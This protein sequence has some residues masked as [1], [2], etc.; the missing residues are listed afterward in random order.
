MRRFLPLLVSCLLF[1]VNATFATPVHLRC[2]YLENP[3]GLDRLAPRLSWQSD[4]TQRDWKQAAYQILVASTAEALK[5]GA[6]VWDS[7]RQD[8]D[9]SVNIAYHGPALESRRRYYWKV[10][11]WDAAGTLSESTQSA[12]WEMGL[13]H[14]DDWKAKWITW[15]NPDSESDLAN[16]RW[17][18]V[19]GQDAMSVPPKTKADFRLTVS[20]QQKPKSAALFVAG[21]GD[22]LAKVN[23]HPVG[24]KNH[25]NT[26]DRFEISDQ[27]VVGENAV[28]L[29][30]TSPD[31]PEFGPDASKPA[32]AALAALVKVV[33]SDGKVQ[34]FATDS[35]WK[36]KLQGN[37]SDWQPASVVAELSDSRLGDPGPLPDPASYL[38]HT[39]Q[40]SKSVR[41]AR[42]YVT[43]LGSYRVSLNGKDVSENVL[44]PEFTDYRKRVLY[45]TYDVTNL[46]ASGSNAIG[47]LLGDGWYGSPL[48][49]YGIHYF[50]LPDR[51]LAQLEIIY[52]DG[53]RDSVL[54][55]GAWK[56][57]PSPIIKSTIYDGE[58]YDARLEQSGWNQS[59]FADT[60]WSSAVVTEAPQIAVSSQIDSPV[61]VV[62]TI[63]PKHITPLS[64]GAYLFDMGQNMVGWATLKVKGS[65]GTKVQLRFAEI[66]NPDGTIYTQNLRNAA[67]TDSYV[68]RGGAEETF[69]PHFTFHGFRY[70]EVSGYPGKPTLGSITGNV[71]SS[72]GGDPVGK[73]QTSS[74]LVNHMWSIGIWGQRGNFVSIPTDCPQR[75]ER[76]GW[77]GDAE[78]F[79][80]TGSYNFDIAA[81][82]QKF[83]QDVIDAQSK[84]GAFSNVSPNVL[85]QEGEFP[86][87]S[88]P[89]IGAPGWGDAGVI[90]PWTAW[91]Q[92]GNTALLEDS[93]TAMD[94]WMELI[95]RHNPDYVRKNAL[96]F[97]FADWLAPDENTDKSLLAT[98]YWAL[99]A[100]MMSQMGHAIGKDADAKRYDELFQHIRGSFQKE[101]V[102]SDGQVGTGTQTSYVVALYTE[103]A[104]VP[105]EREMVD[106][107]VKDI[108]SHNWHLTTGFLG[109][110]FLLFTLSDHGRSDVA[111]RLLLNDTYPS[112]GYMLAKGATTWWERWNGDTGDPAMNSYNH[113]AFGS[114]MAWV[115]RYAAGIDTMPDSPGFKTIVIHPRLDPRMTAA[116]AEYESIYGKIVSDWKGTSTGPFSLRVTIPPNT[117]ANVFL[118]DIPGKHVTRDGKAVDGQPNDGVY[119]LTVGSGSY[120]FEVK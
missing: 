25:W 11:V 23:G 39:F 34:R 101:Y 12:W 17:I 41:S 10:R 22:F 28:E 79:W 67:A 19:A 43:A 58:R 57:S 20:L 1:I 119:M 113:Y 61:K 118:P 87:E 107:L 110:P 111:Y 44:T 26:F 95:Q 88:A 82:S 32:K 27:L 9:A 3:L 35:T 96:G 49:W 73:L 76:L 56:A 40:L 64:N 86:D 81:F 91:V 71:V 21:R 37:Q 24:G 38:R 50:R 59:S 98:A 90:V 4:N 2:E 46:M 114:V 47:A 77:M 7:G 51:F 80:R 65:V 94:R 33:S 62:S 75:D 109:T 63:Q 115:Y 31:P 6:D 105:L 36:A 106:R 85:V 68:L 29:T 15:K 66:L 69:A 84:V 42:L 45:Q 72:I 97:N 104:P 102:K 55:D 89:M 60:N 116:R 93:W 54:T 5:S 92:Y 13:L 117:S 74:D 14:P 8:S 78:V 120:A 112:W 30:L 108:E 100:N 52:T 18:W 83:M 16:V 53:S 99:M 48:T 103:M 70:V